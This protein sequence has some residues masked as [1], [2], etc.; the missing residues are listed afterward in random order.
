VIKQASISKNVIGAF[1]SEEVERKVE[2]Q[3]SY[4]LLDEKGGETAKGECKSQMEKEN[5]V[6]LPKYGNVLSIPFYEVLDISPQNYEIHLPLTSG[7]KIILYGLG[8]YYDDFLRLAVNLRNN[9]LL[10]EL[11]MKEKAAVTGIKAEYAYVDEFMQEKGGGNCEFNVCE[12]GL[13]VLPERGDIFRIPYSNIAEVLEEKYA[14]TFT[15]ETGEKLSLSKMGVN[16]D[17]FKRAYSEANNKLQLNV[18][19]YLKEL[20][21]TANFSV[22]RKLSTIM[23]EGKAAKRRDIEA[24]DPNL[25]NELVRKLETTALKDPYNFLKKLSRED[26][27]SIGLKRGLVGE[28]TGEY[29]WFLIPIYSPNP[30]QP[31]NAVAMEATSQEEGGKATY[32][33]K[34]VDRGSYANLSQEQLNL[35]TDKF[36]REMNRCM[37]DINFRREPIYLTDD[38]LKDSKYRAYKFA[39]QKIPSLRTLRKHFVGR[40][41]HVSPQQWE[42]DVIDLLKFNVTTPDDLAKW[43]KSGV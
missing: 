34:I 19:S 12:T 22:M 32:F 9:V 7:E 28:L 21:P 8:Y 33:F 43:R 37:Q 41:I 3:M 10:K 30:R 6:I 17:L 20:F 18:Q 4:R 11:L 38:K 39:V 24:I 23:R 36:L 1:M 15:M 16:F 5:L 42:Q 25:W 29:V 14:V 31:G 35:E 26:K 27:I 40:V 13:V 2:F